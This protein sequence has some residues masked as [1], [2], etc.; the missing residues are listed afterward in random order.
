MALA[1]VLSQRRVMIVLFR[2]TGPI[3]E[4]CFSR[5]LRTLVSSD[6]CALFELFALLIPSASALHLVTF[7]SP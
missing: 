1:G 2:S 3:F 5:N 7:V 4:K 6:T